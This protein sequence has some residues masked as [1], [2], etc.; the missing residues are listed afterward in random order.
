MFK[1]Y[2][3]TGKSLLEIYKKIISLI[4]YVITIMQKTRLQIHSL[5]LSFE[6]RIMVTS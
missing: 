4:Q 1:Y 6:E 3:I 2:A 5:L